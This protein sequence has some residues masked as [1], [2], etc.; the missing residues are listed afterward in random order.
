MAY[1]LMSDARIVNLAKR[2]DCLAWLECLARGLESRVE[3]KA[4]DNAHS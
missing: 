1:Q 4:R 3:S 2:G